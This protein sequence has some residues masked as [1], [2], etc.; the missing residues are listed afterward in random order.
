M[1]LLR[2]VILSKA[3]DLRLLFVDSVATFCGRINNSGG[4]KSLKLTSPVAAVARGPGSRPGTGL[5][6][7]QIWKQ[8]VAIYP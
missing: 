1:Q 5:I 4:P 6:F 3:K 8:V 2:A 7:H